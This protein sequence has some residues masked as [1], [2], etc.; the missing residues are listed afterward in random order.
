MIAC[1]LQSGATN[2][3]IAVFGI[4]CSV[5]IPV[6]VSVANCN[7]VI[8]RALQFRCGGVGS[9]AVATG[10]TQDGHKKARHKI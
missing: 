9:F 3:L 5:I 4:M 6:C 7:S 2:K 10:E 8:M 1:I